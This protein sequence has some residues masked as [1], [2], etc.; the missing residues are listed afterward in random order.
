M[1]KAAELGDAESQA[2]LADIL[3]VDAESLREDNEE[4][5]KDI[6]LTLEQESFSWMLKAAEQE[7]PR[8]QYALGYCFLNGTGT[9]KN[10]EKAFLWFQQ[11]AKNGISGAKCCLGEL[12]LYGM[13]TPQNFHQAVYWLEQAAEESDDKI[14][15][16]A[17]MK[18]GC[19][20]HEG[21]G[22]A[23]DQERG[24]SMLREAAA[25]GNETAKELLLEAQSEQRV[26]KPSLIGMICGRFFGT[27]G[28]AFS[29]FGLLVQSTFYSMRQNP[30][31]NLRD[32][33]PA[34]C[35]FGLFIHAVIF[36]FFLLFG[37]LKYAGLLVLSP[38]IAI[39]E[40][41]ERK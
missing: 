6:I 23:V 36:C 29:A 12:Y 4:N 7:F 10:L 38:F 33:S 34:G 28:E 25:L 5:D 26:T 2:D 11:A 22:V 35:I 31:I 24:L 32:E 14:K 41:L 37:I 18:L 19:A 15:A 30:D 3:R 27:I 20:Y 13:G 40:Y 8:A 1:R 9:L 21:I 39:Y 17:K 16:I